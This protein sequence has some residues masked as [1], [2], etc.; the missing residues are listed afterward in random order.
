MEIKT[1]SD[2]AFF[3]CPR[4]HKLPHAGKV[5]RCTPVRCG[6]EENPGKQA[7][8]KKEIKIKKK[9]I[10]N[11]T[12]NSIIPRDS[13]DP[14]RGVARQNA[15]EGRGTEAVIVGRA[16]GRLSFRDALVPIPKNLTGA[17]AE[18][19]TKKAFNDAAP[20]AAR[21][22]IFKMK[23][24]DDKE[25]IE[26]SKDILDRAGHGKQDKGSG[27]GGPLIVIQG[28][29]VALPFEGIKQ[30]APKVVEATAVTVTSN[31]GEKK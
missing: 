6:D 8:V 10:N 30:A 11:E 16:V 24:G 27:A 12:I 20:E 18:E 22:L 28:A 25:M 5:G 4:H 1:K 26:A 3:A 9:F 23:F 17:Q 2:D 13:N 14:D 19:W 31:D 29:N 15:R 21:N 7:I